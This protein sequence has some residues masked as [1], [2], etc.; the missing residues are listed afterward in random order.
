MGMGDGGRLASQGVRA[1]EGAMAHRGERGKQMVVVS[2]IKC[3][4]KITEIR[5][6]EDRGGKKAN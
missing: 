3:M 1:A 5:M 2:V 6:F 4:K